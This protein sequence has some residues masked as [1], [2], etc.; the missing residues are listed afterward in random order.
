MD[1]LNGLA[2][3]FV[4]RVPLIF[5]L[6]KVNAFDINAAYVIVIRGLV[7]DL[8]IGKVYGR[9]PLCGAGYVGA[10]TCLVLNADGYVKVV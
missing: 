9:G 7:I 1:Y 2:L 3:A 4:H 6:G 10:L 8:S 5:R